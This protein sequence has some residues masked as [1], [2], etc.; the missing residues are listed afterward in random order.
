[1]SS[2]AELRSAL[3]RA[4]AEP[5]SEHDARALAQHVE[6]L[7]DALCEAARARRRRAF[8][9]T[10]SFSPKVFLPLTNLCRDFC[11]YCSFRRSPGE[12]GAWT[13]APAELEE[14][15]ARGREAG[16]IEALFCLGDRPESVFPSYRELLRGFGHESTVDYLVEACQRALAHGLLPHT[17]AGLLTREELARLRPLNASMGLMLENVSAR[18]CGRGMPHQR[19][20]DKRPELRLQMMQSAGELRIPFTTGIL[21]GIGETL[22]ERIES[23]LAIRALQR[24]YGNI[25][26]VIVQSYRQGPLVARWQSMH[27]PSERE[28]ASAIAL[29]RLILPDEVSVQAPPNLTPGAIR[30]LIGAGLDDFG[31]ISPV[32][33]DYINPGHRWPQLDRLAEQCAAEGFTLAARLPI[34]DRFAR[35][36]RFVDAGL[37]PALAAAE[38]R[39]ALFGARGRGLTLVGAQA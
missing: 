7:H 28:L 15:L 3:F 4:A 16:A 17:N 23:L 38:P 14:W 30:G 26:E 10:L 6:H 31:G 21:L 33:P 20:R 22:D 5:I 36:P 13:M 19:A 32:T 8:G 12:P 29:A 9:S 1:M 34:A 35:D 11:D 39:R 27:E 24:E 2:D 37:A 18:L 25:Q